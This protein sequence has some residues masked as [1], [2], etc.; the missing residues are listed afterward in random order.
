[1]GHPEATAATEASVS[2]LQHRTFS[3]CSFVNPDA[4]L[5]A[6]ASVS[7]QQPEHISSVRLVQPVATLAIPTSVTAPQPLT[8]RAVSCRQPDDRLAIPASVSRVPLS[9]SAVNLGHSAATL[10]AA[11]SVNR[12]QYL[13]LGD[14]S[15]GQLAAESVKLG[16]DSRSNDC[17]P[18]KPAPIRNCRLIAQS[19]TRP[20][21]QPAHLVQ[22]LRDA[23]H[24]RIFERSGKSEP[25]P[26]WDGRQ[27][28]ARRE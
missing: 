28:A 21:M 15:R 19:T 16:D 20:Q 3:T 24:V 10:A 4:M 1:M 8:S 5:A 7:R 27:T 25:R 9:D 13:K 17:S 22:M 23:F 2:N 18:G 6:A 14:V 26:R 12:P 11:A